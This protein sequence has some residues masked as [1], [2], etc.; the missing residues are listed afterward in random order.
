MTEDTEKKDQVPYTFTTQEKFVIFIIL[1]LMFINTASLSMLIPSYGSIIEDFEI[2]KSLIYIPDAMLVLVSAIFSV[3]WGYY[4]DRLD[5]TKIVMGGAFLSGIGLVYSAFCN[6]FTSLLFARLV[7]GAGMGCIL[8]VG[9]SILSDIIPP[10]DRSGWFGFLAI[11]SSLSNAAGNGMAAFLGPLELIKGT[12][13]WQVPFLI[14]A[15][16]AVFVIIL[17]MFVRMPDMGSKEEDLAQLQEMDDMEYGYQINQRE[18]VKMLKK[19]TNKYLIINGFFSIVPGTILVFVL[20]TTL[21][22]PVEGMFADLPDVLRTQVSTIMA[23]LVG[24]GYLI[25]NIFLSWLGDVV[26]LKKK[27]YR[28]ILALVTQSIAI[29]FIII[30]VFVLQPVS[31]DKMPDYPVDANGAVAIPTSEVTSYMIDTIFAIF[32]EYPNYVLFFIFSFIGSFFGAGFVPNKNAILVDVNLPEHRGTAT[33][34]FQLTEQLGKSATLLLTS[35]LLI[36]IGSYKGML[37]IA[38]LFWVPS[39]ILW[40]MTSRIIQKDLDDK[41]MV[42]RERTQVSFIDYF[43]ELEMAID[44]GIQLIQDAKDILLKKP[45][46][47]ENLIDMAIRKYKW[48]VKKASKQD[49]SELEVKSHGL[50]DNA[51]LFK[52][53]LLMLSK[54]PT[55]SQLNDLFLKIDTLWEES[56]F[57]KIEVLYDSAS[58]KVVESR[59]RRNYNPIESVSILKGAIDIIDRVIRLTADRVL[60]DTKKLTPEEEE[61]QERIHH[62]LI[63]AQ[64]SKSNTVLLKDKLNH[65]VTTV[66]NSNISKEELESMIELTSEY[67]LKL[68]DI[69]M[70]TFEGK[71]AKEIK[72]LTEDIDILFK[73]YDEWQTN[74]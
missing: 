22:D 24:V 6:T 8:P 17:L 68:Q 69:V 14:L 10:E 56:D 48:I 4:T 34:F 53:D 30:M 35:A 2:D 18:L 65:L 31:I 16:F 49:M 44:D 59:L 1:I 46:E 23:G 43:F 42:L 51:L 54:K 15:F 36:L 73:E 27:K 38:T 19:P 63:L 29:P 72:K 26:Y 11:F 45:K 33:S 55:E 40:Y 62:L 5:R 41:A 58:L 50:M 64:K 70:E 67:G 61:F 74:E 3:I 60:D 66:L 7:T 25:G 71:T 39:A 32:R 13:G 37:Y 21:S 12:R 28:A 57:G 52:A 47:A 20:I 9:I